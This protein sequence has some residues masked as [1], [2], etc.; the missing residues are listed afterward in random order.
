MKL[1]FTIFGLKRVGFIFIEWPTALLWRTSFG[2]PLQDGRYT[3]LTITSPPQ[4]VCQFGAVSI[5]H[6][7]V[8][9]TT[10]YYQG[11]YRSRHTPS[12][13]IR[14]QRSLCLSPIQGGG[15]GGFFS[16]PTYG[17][18][19]EDTMVS[20][21]SAKATCTVLCCPSADSLEQLR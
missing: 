11:V 10:S 20:L 18:Q 21:A 19:V 2:T 5:Q 4:N 1:I 16:H 6:L 17:H 9:A 3:S 8:S 7:H 14:G 12:R 15:V 13:T